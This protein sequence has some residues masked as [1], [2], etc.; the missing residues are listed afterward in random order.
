MTLE[1]RLPEIHTMRKSGMYPPISDTLDIPLM[2]CTISLA[3]K[4]GQF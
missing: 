2:G 3:K 4:L 1:I